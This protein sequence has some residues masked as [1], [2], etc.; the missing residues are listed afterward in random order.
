MVLISNV[1][2]KT[3]IVMAKSSKQAFLFMYTGGLPLKAGFQRSALS[4][5]KIA[6]G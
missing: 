4:M 1:G 3:Q 6:Q 5:R 2:T